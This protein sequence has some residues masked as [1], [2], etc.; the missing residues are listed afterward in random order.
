MDR[1][2]E[3]IL[4]GQPVAY[5]R[6]H[7][8]ALSQFQAQRI[9]SIAMT[10][11]ETAA[12]DAQYDGQEGGRLLR[13]REVE[14]QMLGVGIGVFNAA[15]KNDIVRNDQI[16]TRRNGCPKACNKNQAAG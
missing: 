3:L 7:E 8:P 16:S 6:G 14:L 1:R 5:G 12:V 11:P 10:G 13:S 4:R 2:R 15:L 9:V